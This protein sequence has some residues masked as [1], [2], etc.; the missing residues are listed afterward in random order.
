MN[1]DQLAVWSQV[2]S[3]LLFMV[4]LVAI[5]IKW[6]APAVL[7]AQEAHNQ[8][9]VQAERHRDEA[10]AALEALR[11]EID[12]AKRD[13]DLIRERAKHQAELEKEAAIAQARAAGER[14][15]RNA[16][17]ELDR[18]RAEARERLRGEL[19]EKALAFA[20]TRATSRMNAATNVTLV[21]RLIATLEQGE[22]HG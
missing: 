7:A 3:A 9:I 5:W 8:Q 21:D 12:G 1:Y 11:R 6:I 17:G 2:I 15:L 19:I 14:S 10:K 4:A 20:Q 13:A 22:H 18:V 16:E